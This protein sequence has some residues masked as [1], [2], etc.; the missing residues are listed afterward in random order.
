MAAALEQDLD[1]V[2]AFALAAMAAGG[3]AGAVAVQAQCDAFLA[4]L[5][6]A[7]GT[8]PLDGATVLVQKVIS[9]RHRR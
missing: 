2:Q 6:F 9:I 5:G 8:L 3:G 4:R 7:A 1:A